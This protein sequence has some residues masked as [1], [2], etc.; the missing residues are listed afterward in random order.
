VREVRGTPSIGW[1]GAAI[2]AAVPILAALVVGVGVASILAALLG[3][4]VAARVAGHHGALQGGAAAALF[5]VVTGL[6]DTLAPAPRLPADTVLL[7]VVDAL[8]LAA[9]ALG[10]WLSRAG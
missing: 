1:P 6:I 2:G 10:G 4:F 3:G 7:I 5:I 8:H 9:G